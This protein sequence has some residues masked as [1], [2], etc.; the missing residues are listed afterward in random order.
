MCVSNRFLPSLLTLH[1]RW[2]CV[3][4]NKSES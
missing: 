1:S 2:R 4:V 3:G